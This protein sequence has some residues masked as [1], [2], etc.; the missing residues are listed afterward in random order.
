MAYLR[1]GFNVS[2]FYKLALLPSLAQC[3]DPEL[4][5]ATKEKIKYLM[6]KYIV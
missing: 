6:T 5:K 3:V 2:Q 4:F 1:D